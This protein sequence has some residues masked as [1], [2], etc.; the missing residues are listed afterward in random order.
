V[1]VFRAFAGWRYDP[2]RVTLD[3][4]VSG[5]PERMGAA[6]VRA[7]YLQSVYHVARLIAPPGGKDSPPTDSG[8]AC[9]AAH[10]DAWREDGVFLQDRPAIYL[11]EQRFRREGA[12]CVRRGFLCTVRLAAWDADGVQ[13]LACAASGSRIDWLAGMRTLRG[14]TCPVVGIIGDPAGD[15]SRALATLVD[16]D[17]LVAITD[18]ESVEHRIWVVDDPDRLE[19]LLGI[20]E[21]RT[22]GVADGR[23]LYDAALLYQREVRAAIREAGRQ[24]PEPGELAGDHVLACAIPAGD[25]GL[26]LPETP[27]P[28][29]PP[30]LAGLVFHLQW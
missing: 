24:P 4:V 25:P 21:G 20:A 7:G 18:A 30:V 2:G 27:A 8:A 23:E 11:L 16:Y 14:Q 17:P 26:F 22:F 5:P 10:L 19:R 28:I 12:P 3:Q 13:P 1:A 29:V 6:D 15:L 9:A